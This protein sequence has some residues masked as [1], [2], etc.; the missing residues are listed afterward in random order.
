M[1][2]VDIDYSGLIAKANEYADKAAAAANNKGEYEDVLNAF[3]T[4]ASTFD[5]FADGWKEEAYNKG[6]AWGDEKWNSLMNNDLMSGLDMTAYDMAGTLADQADASAKT[7]D[8]TAKIAD[9]TSKSNEE[10]KYLREIAERQVIN[11]FTT[12]EIKV[13]MS[14]MQNSISSDMDI[15]GFVR[16]LEVELGDSMQRCAQ[17]V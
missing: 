12:A 7:A 13:D 14:G 1:P 5:V 11:K 6:A 15:D 8:N 2:F 10:L 9:N 16:K 17:G 3:N 4:G